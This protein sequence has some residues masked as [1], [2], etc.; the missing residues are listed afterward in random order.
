M[1][2]SR[3]KS[4]RRSRFTSKRLIK[5]VA[6]ACWIETLEDRRLL[7]A[8]RLD[9]EFG[10][11]GFLSINFPGSTKDAGTAVTVTQPDGKIL[12]AGEEIDSSEKLEVARLNPEG[13]LD[14]TFGNNGHVALQFAALN[15]TQA[16]SIAVQPDGKILVGGSFGQP[17][18]F[19]VNGFPIDGHAG[20]VRLNA[21]GTLDGTFGNGGLAL[22][23]QVF[24]SSRKGHHL[25][26]QPDGKIVWAGAVD[27][28]NRLDFALT[29]FTSGGQ[30]DNTFGSGG[31]SSVDF[32]FIEAPS[33]LTTDPSGDLVV[34]GTINSPDVTN[35]RDIGVARFSPDGVP[36]SSFG[37][38][39]TAI[40]K[41][42]APY[43][44]NGA[45]N[46]IVDSNGRIVLGGGA[47]SAVNNFDF[48]LVRLTPDGE[49]D[50][51]FGSGGRVIADVTGNGGHDA[52]DGLALQ[53][54]G[55][56]LAAG[57]SD[58]ALAVGRFDSDGSL[59]TS[60]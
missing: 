21:N 5:A 26:L 4:A 9:P 7:S 16:D 45:E 37:N 50:P 20:V 41:P 44:N 43:T 59:D 29:R 22:S 49:L 55:K 56:I 23:N 46:V 17:G 54:D 32:G 36:D 40:V 35:E 48:S 8:V 15:L 19:S 42:L 58:G 39:G 53:P 24:T 11:N 51:S 30:I 14:T 2:K 38:A 28:P 3:S 27:G 52:I 6:D 60:F 25:V 31:V 12:V 47:F 13:N 34:A 18:Q 10:T 57:I 33:D 1:L